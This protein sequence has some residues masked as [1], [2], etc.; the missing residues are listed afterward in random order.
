MKF[1]NHTFFKFVLGFL[2]IVIA[3]MLGIFFLGA[4]SAP[5]PA[6]PVAGQGQ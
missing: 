6:A 1:F 3:G 2:A 4:R 5:T